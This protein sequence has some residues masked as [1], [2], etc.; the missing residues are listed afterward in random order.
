MPRIVLLGDSV[1][2]NQAY[3]APGA[4]TIDALTARL[5][6]GWSATLLAQDGSTTDEVARQIMHLPRDATHLVVS[7]GGNDALSE[8]G[9]LSDDATSVAEALW[10]LAQVTARFERRYREMVRR[11]RGRGLPTLVCT[12]YHGNFPEP[13]FQVVT[14]TALAVFNDA[15]IRAAWSAQLPILDLRR[16]CSEPEDYANDI[17]PSARGSAKI[18]DAV[19][20]GLGIGQQ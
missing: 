8:A 10:K 15:I 19:M 6:A 3:V 9:V 12:I 1:F 16:V 2:D 13:H 18:A 7:T 4:S 20:K 17:E 5:P 11:V 14:A